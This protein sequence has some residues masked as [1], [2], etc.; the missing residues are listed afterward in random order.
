MFEYIIRLIESISQI[1]SGRKPQ[2][3]EEDEP[4]PP[5]RKPKKKPEKDLEFP[6][7]D[8]WLIPVGV[9]GHAVSSSGWTYTD[10]VPNS[11]TW[12]WTATWDRDLCDKLLGGD[13][14]IRKPK[15]NEEEQRWQGGASAHFCVGRTYEEGISQYVS[16]EHRS[17]HAGAGQ[18]LRWDGQKANYDGK[19]LSGSRTSIG[20]ETVEV[21]FERQDIPREDDWINVYDTDGKNE[22]W[23]QPWTDEQVDMMIFLGR[24]IVEKYP[25]ITFLDHHGHM[26]TSPGYK[27][28]PA[29]AFPFAKVLSGIYKKEIPDVWTPFFMIKPR[30]RALEVL[31]YDLGTWGADGD[32]GTVSTNAL[33]QFQKDRGI[34][35]DGKWSTF[36]CWEIYFALQDKDLS[37]EQ[38][39]MIA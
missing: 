34:H 20:I 28:D 10:G 21:G 24:K 4:A 32:W 19:F 27:Q 30:Q 6:I 15:W 8:S 25:N 23:I 14:A 2:I 22:M 26:D 38:V 29:L 37:I 18:S 13:D 1:F 7:D 36:V 17:W 31:G 16:L 3:P 11:I 5:K 33:K 35:P 39:N 9:P 12:H